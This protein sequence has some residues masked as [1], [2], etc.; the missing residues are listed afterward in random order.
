MFGLGIRYL[1][2]WAMAAVDGA[3]KARPEWPPHPDRIFMALA[4]AWFET[5]QNL[6]EGEALRWLEKLSP[7]HLSVS[8]AE[9]RKSFRSESPPI[10]YVP[11]NDTIR[12][13]KIPDTYDLGKL[14]DAG[15]SL[16]PEFRTRQARGFPT[17]IPHDPVVYL[18]WPNHNTDGF[19][20]P[21]T[22]LCRKVV[23]VGNSAS[24]I[25]MWLEL[26]PPSANLLPVD[27]LATCR[28]RVFGPG[29]LDYLE[30]R[31]NRTA[32][33]NFG[34]LSSKLQELRDK[35][36]SVKK[37]GKFSIK[38]LKGSEK[39]GATMAYN[40]EIKAIESSIA[41]VENQMVDFGGIQ[42]V[43]LRP[44][45]GLWQG[46][47][48]SPEEV[49][50]EGGGTIFDTRL[51]VLSLSGKRLSLPATLKL[52]DTVRAALLSNCVDPVPEWVS[53][54]AGNGART[55]K[56]HLALFPLPFVGHAHADGRLIGVALALPKEI[57]LMEA[58]RVLEPWLRDEYGLP[59]QI[60]LFNS[61]WRECTLELDTREVKPWSLRARQWTRR[62]AAWASVTPVVLDRHFDGKSRWQQAT[63][64]IKDSCE[65]IGLPRPDR[66][67]L[68][69]VSLVEGVPH[70]KSFACLKRKTDGGHMCH[71][72]AVIIFS[73]SVCGPIILG[74][75][76][77]RG[78]GLFRPI[79][80]GEES[81]A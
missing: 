81:N 69:P 42:P 64:S 31:C 41:K 75:G 1:N 16:L 80:H 32:V 68:H 14:K 8:D 62:S 79:D 77:F 25:Q 38:G 48:R 59:R 40:E 26:N 73:E 50:S 56:P 21:L 7:P 5:G 10:S 57:D 2:G 71:S 47:E 66:V 65:R 34:Y 36:Q 58:S 72:H 55:S 3:K 76:R 52:T 35:L 78:Y 45:P 17:A 49:G 54:H 15:L 24:L 30:A 74:A 23:S 27:G 46:Y 39:M 4:A 28:L 43:S 61:S 12:G 37:Q 63:E 33:V 6:A 29:R 13:K 9:V 11:V 18:I 44:E 53:G 67:L 22:S 19:Y 60:R 51:L 70:A 20:E